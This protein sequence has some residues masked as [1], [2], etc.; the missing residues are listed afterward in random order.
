M[1][2]RLLFKYWGRLWRVTRSELAARYAGSALGL[3]WVIVYPLAILAAYAA[4]YALIL[5]VRVGNLGPW[6]YVLYMFSGL[7]P[8]LSANEAITQ[9]IGSLTANRHLLNNTTFPIDLLPPKAVLASQVTMV[10]GFALIGI[11]AAST[12]MLHPTLVLLPLLWI[13]QALALTGCVWILS[14]VNVLVRDL[15]A[16]AGVLLLGLLVTSPIAYAPSMVPAVLAPFVALNPFAV[17]LATYQRVVALGEW[18]SAASLAG[19]SLG[20]LAIFFAG[21]WCFGRAKRVLLDYV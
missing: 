18:P 13:L 2:V 20:S 21:G 11:A 4:L 17:F 3:A 19:L 15:Q 12:G 7:V 10:T 6:Q 16:A 14:V 9:G 8:F 1:S 5:K